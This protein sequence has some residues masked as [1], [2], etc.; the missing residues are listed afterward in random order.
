MSEMMKAK[1]K[2]WGGVYIDDQ[3]A[4]DWLERGVRYLERNPEES[5]FYSFSGRRAVFV[6]RNMEYGAHRYEVFDVTVNRTDMVIVNDEGEIVNMYP[7]NP[8]ED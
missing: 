2:A 8:L 4:D 7:E 6:I 1:L 5:F 3:Q